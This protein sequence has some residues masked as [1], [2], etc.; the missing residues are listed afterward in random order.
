MRDGW[1]FGRSLSCGRLARQNHRPRGSL[2]VMSR[3]ASSAAEILPQAEDDVDPIWAAF[4]RA[5][6]AKEP[7]TGEQRRL[8]EAA[9]RGPFRQAQVVSS[10]IAARCGSGT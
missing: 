6:L 2:G 4:E 8:A 9:R 10:E 7:E 3:R 5:P 1:I